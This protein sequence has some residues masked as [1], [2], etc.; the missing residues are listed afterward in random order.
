M[1][2]TKRQLE[3]YNFIKDFMLKNGVT[4]TIREISAGV[5]LRS[6]SV[7]Y[8]HYSKLIDKGLIVPFGENTKRFTV[9]G[10]K[11]VEEEDN[12]F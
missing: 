11:Y 4:P 6:S 3:V 7:A 2:L 12:G 5:G 9:K 8:L 1:E 10:L